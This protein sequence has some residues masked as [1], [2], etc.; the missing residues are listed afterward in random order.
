MLYDPSG[1]VKWGAL[2]VAD[3]LSARDEFRMVILEIYR[4]RGLGTRDVLV[5]LNRIAEVYHPQWFIPEWNALRAAEQSLDFDAWRARY[6]IRMQKHFTSQSKSDVNFGI[7]SMGVDFELGRIRLP[8]VDGE[9]RAQSQLLINEATTYPS[10]DSDDVLMAAW[11]GKYNAR[12]LRPPRVEATLVNGGWNLP[13][14]NMFQGVD[15]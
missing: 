4:E 7:D 12:F 15:W 10:G 2:V 5:H 9:S 6:G 11:L 13:E 3:L 1:G 14:L 8:Y